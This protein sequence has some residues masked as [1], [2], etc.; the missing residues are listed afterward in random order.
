MI[1]P[2]DA[3]YASKEY[4][5]GLRP[6]TLC[7]EVL[8]L[9]PPTRRLRLLDVGCG[10]GR[11]AVFFARNGYEVTAFDLSPEGIDKTIALAEQSRTP[12]TAFV[13]DLREFRLSEPFDIIFSTGSLHYLPQR[14]R[15]A[16]IADYRAH[17]LPGGINAINVFVQ[18]PFLKVPPDTEDLAHP[19]YSGELFLHYHDWRIE[20]GVEEMFDCTSSGIPHQHCV[21]KVIA[22]RSG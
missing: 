3:R 1:N 17:T 7:H 20:Y 2:Y 9:M 8:R 13:A 19:W 10:E 6:S 22:R 12:I 4:Y 11:D 18:K 21:N 5:W 14:S 15:V 16:V